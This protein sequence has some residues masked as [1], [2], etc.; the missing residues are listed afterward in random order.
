MIPIHIWGLK[1]P[2]GPRFFST[3]IAELNS[4]PFRFRMPIVHEAEDYSDLPN[5]LIDINAEIIKQKGGLNIQ[6]LFLDHHNTKLSSEKVKECCYQLIQFAYFCSKTHVIICDL[7][8]PGAGDDESIAQ[9]EQIHCDLRKIA[10]QWSCFATYIDFY[11]IIY[12]DHWISPHHLGQQG[13]EKL[14]RVLNRTLNGIPPEIL[15]C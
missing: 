8:G 9:S 4:E 1:L 11:E 10:A 6:I 2:P 13:Q 15:N 14:A 5:I 12:P 3:Q 7:T